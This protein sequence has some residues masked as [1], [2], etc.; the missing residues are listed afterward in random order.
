[1]LQLYIPLTAALTE[2][3]QNH[4][5]VVTIED[6]ILADGCGQTVAQRHSGRHSKT[7]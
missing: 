7:G 5:V 4:R 6:G 1:M 2:I 3:S